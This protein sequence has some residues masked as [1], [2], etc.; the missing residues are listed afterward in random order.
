MLIAGIEPVPVV[1]GVMADALALGPDGG[2]EEP[3][4]AE[5][6]GDVPMGPVSEVV[7]RADSVPEVAG[8]A[9][10]IEASAGVTG[11]VTVPWIWLTAPSVSAT[12]AVTAASV[13]V[14]GA[15]T[16]ASVWVSGAV[17]AASVW[18]SGAVTAASV[19]VS[20]AVTAA[21]V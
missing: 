12:G 13:W 15:V 14:S 5:K 3:F 8:P 17:T 18:V 1:A 20:G 21:S 6:T 10:G 4:V 9:V 2:V 7:G 19:W 11:A 16:A